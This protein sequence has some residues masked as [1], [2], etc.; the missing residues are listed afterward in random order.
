MLEA[1]HIASPAYLQWFH[2]PMLQSLSVEGTYRALDGD[3]YILWIESVPEG[4]TS[5]RI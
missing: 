5:Q 3:H 2:L 1:L 4:I